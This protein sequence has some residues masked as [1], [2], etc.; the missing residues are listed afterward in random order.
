MWPIYGRGVTLFSSEILTT[1]L[2]NL[3]PDPK[4]I[5][6]IAIIL[7]HY[8]ILSTTTIVVNVFIAFE[9]L[10][11]RQT[12]TRCFILESYWTLKT[13]VEGVFSLLTIMVVLFTGRQI[14][15]K[16]ENII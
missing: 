4:D 10:L 15:P 7:L 14:S 6:D 5:F 13:N 16:S 2:S 11:N 8:R 3:S 12:L 1:R 9:K